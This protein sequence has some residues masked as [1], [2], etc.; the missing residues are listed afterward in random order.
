MRFT[1]DCTTPPRR[2]SRP[3]RVRLFSLLLALLLP[4]SGLASSVPTTMRVAMV[5]SPT[6]ELHPLRVMERD[7]VSLLNLVYESLIVLDDDRKPSPGLATSW[8]SINNGQTWLFHIR[9]NVYFHDGRK[10]T[11]YDVKAT[12]DLIKEISE[13]DVADNEKGLYCKL[14]VYYTSAEADDEQTLRVRAS[15]DVSSYAL[16]YAMT[17]PVL[18]AQSARDVNPPGTG[19]YRVMSYSPGGELVLMGNENWWSAPPHVGEITATWFASDS[20]ALAAFEAEN[21]DILMTRST[22]AVRYR[23]TLTGHSAYTFS[24][25]QL[26]CLLMNNSSAN[27]QKKEMRKAV[28]H[29]ID[30]NRLI[31]NVYQNIVT[32]TN[33]IQSPSSWLYNDSAKGYGYDPAEANKILDDLGWSTFDDTGVRTKTTEAGTKQLELRMYYYDEAGNGLRKEAANEIAAMLRAVGFRVK[34][35]P[36]Q[37]T[38]AAAKLKAGDF[39]LCLAA[40]NF[41]AVPDPNFI[42]LPDG[43]GNY[44]RYKTDKDAM[45]KL[46]QQLRKAS[47]EEDF[48]ATWDEIQTMMAEDLPF[49]PLYW[50]NGV[51]LTQYAYSRVRDIREFELLRTIEEYQ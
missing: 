12:M 35:T 1:H 34:V 6:M 19:P 18:Q 38:D 4:A 47:T 10:L 23:G 27:L 36:Y 32:S 44:A 33:T 15:K 25:R 21:V 7:A 43:Y 31:A 45:R 13:S 40:Y 37:F 29:A 3:S 16:L 51:V 24:T 11:A 22:A 30:K 49:L 5:T 50:R 20:A 14:P 41:D 39:D 28:A 46:C 17:F 9:D 8:E 48:K 2:R 26:E 42:L